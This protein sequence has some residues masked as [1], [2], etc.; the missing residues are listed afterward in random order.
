MRHIEV[1]GRAWPEELGADAAEVA[2]RLVEYFGD[3]ARKVRMRIGGT[4][5]SWMPEGAR[6]IV[7]WI[8]TPTASP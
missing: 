6:M 3:Q 1:G 8:R 2:W 7:G 4:E 5:E